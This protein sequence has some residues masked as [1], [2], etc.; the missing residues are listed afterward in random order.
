MRK[1][2]GLAQVSRA[3]PPHRVARALPRPR[4]SEVIG[5]AFF[6]RKCIDDPEDEEFLHAAGCLPES[7]RRF[8]V[9]PL[10]IMSAARSMV[11]AAARKCPR[12]AWHAASWE[13][14]GAAG[15]LAASGGQYERRTK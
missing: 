9:L 4:A 13:S 15:G 5:V 10:I 1:A 12:A 14:E 8:R 2:I 6:R 7:Y 3:F 11:P